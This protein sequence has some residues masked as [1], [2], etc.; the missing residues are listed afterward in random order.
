[1]CV[2]S[3]PPRG[4]PATEDSRWRAMSGRPVAG[5]EVRIVDD[6]GNALA[7]DGHAVGQLQVRGPWVTAGYHG[8]GPRTTSDGWFDTG[9]VGTIDPLGYV[10]ITD[11]TKDLIKSGGEWISSVELE[12]ELSALPGIVEAAVIAV[13]DPRWEERPLAIISWTGAGEPDLRSFRSAL[14]ERIAR[15]MVPENWAIMDCL[16]KTSVGKIDK[17]QLRDYAARGQI[18]IVQEHGF[19]S[20]E[21]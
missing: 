7:E 13:P 11:R 15:F 4:T 12:G 20:E 16:P 9:D 6:A 18:E 19:A 1:M 21:H 3:H 5:M 8:E 14:R 10:R 2:L 17:K